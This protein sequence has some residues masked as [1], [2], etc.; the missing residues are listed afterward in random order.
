[1]NDTSYEQKI[2]LWGSQMLA[3]LSFVLLA[4]SLTV[5]HFK[6]IT[7]TGND[8]TYAERAPIVLDKTARYYSVPSEG[9]S[10]ISCAVGKLHYKPSVSHGAIPYEPEMSANT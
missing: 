9:I 1:M 8:T 4:L 5:S 3:I 10:A 7:V 2:M 6:S